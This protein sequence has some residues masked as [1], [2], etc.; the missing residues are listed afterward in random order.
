MMA[1]LQRNREGYCS[2]SQHQ[3]AYPRPLKGVIR[4]GQ[5]VSLRFVSGMIVIKKRTS[6]EALI[7][8]VDGCA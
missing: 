1:K 5:E 4:L 3:G 6:Y 8:N 7:C 2:G